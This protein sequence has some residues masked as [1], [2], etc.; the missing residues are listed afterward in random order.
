LKTLL[1]TL[2]IVG[3]LALVTTSANAALNDVQAQ[4]IMK[5][6]GC[7]ACHAVDKKRVGPAFKDVA[8][9]R[10]SDAV[11]SLEKTVRA[12]SKNVYGTIPMPPSLP[13]KISDADLHDL[14]EWILTK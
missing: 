3:S 9:K 11:A 1:I 4:D 2:S 7:A 10:K 13:D 12:G 5:K 8:L 14:V 6:S